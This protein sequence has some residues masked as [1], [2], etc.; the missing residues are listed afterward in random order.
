[1]LHCF[2]INVMSPA[3]ESSLSAAPLASVK[4]IAVQDAE[5]VQGFYFLH[6]RLGLSCLMLQCMLASHSHLL[7]LIAALLR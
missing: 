6:L 4:D 2:V 3:V 1:M 7:L 5:Q